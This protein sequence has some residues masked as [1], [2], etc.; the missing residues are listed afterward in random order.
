MNP[1]LI[2][3][4]V[5]GAAVTMAAAM[6]LTRRNVAATAPAKL[7]GL[8]LPELKDRVN[9]VAA[10]RVQ[11]GS[12]DKGLMELTR[13]G[14]DWVLANRASYPAK[15][16]RVKSLLVQMAELSK[17]QELTSKPENYAR[18]GVQEPSQWKEPVVDPS[19]QTATPPEGVA[20]TQVTLK[21]AKGGEIASLIVGDVKWGTVPQSYVR[22]PT[23]ARAW[24]ASGRVEAPRSMTELIELEFVKVPQARVKSAVVTLASGGVVEAKKTAPAD[25]S[26]VL[27]NVPE[28][29]KARAGS[30][31]SLGGVLASVSLED[32]AAI[33]SIDFA[34]KEG[35]N[36]VK[37]ATLEVRTF[38]GLVLIAELAD[39]EGQ[40]WSKWSAA[41]DESVTVPEGATGLSKPEEVKAEVAKLNEKFSRFAFAIPAWK[42]NIMKS[43]MDSLL[44]QPTPEG[45]T[46]PGGMPPGM[47]GGMPALPPGMT[48]PPSGQ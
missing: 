7:E 8:I 35:S 13:A 38:D 43:T 21:D 46:P 44:E 9:D 47:P 36:V 6:V 28:G 26:F 22:R 39:R 12:S 30:A 45:G 4:L 3:S 19:G 2:I 14:N 27:Q 34:G 24:R 32:V 1:K 31:D 16:D 40:T 23:E 11:F 17:D 18:L 29:R 37:A 25:A 15:F 41:I 42:S 10:I 48:M 33:D 20:P 5:L